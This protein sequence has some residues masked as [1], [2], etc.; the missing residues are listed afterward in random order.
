MKLVMSYIEW[1]MMTHW[2]SGYFAKMSALGVPALKSLRICSCSGIF[3]VMW[4]FFIR[5]NVPLEFLV[6][7][8]ISMNVHTIS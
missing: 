7:S 4:D 2:I 6:S 5:A 8:N 1:S 3:G